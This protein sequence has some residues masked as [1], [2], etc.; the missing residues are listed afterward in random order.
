MILKVKKDNEELVIKIINGE[1]EVNF[2]YIQM[3]N[4]LFNQD[5]VRL[6]FEDDISDE[7]KGYIN[8]LFTE[9][10]NITVEEERQE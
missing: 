2:D 6:T 1:E 9:I 4:T 10:C 8:N 3:I 5:E 7:D